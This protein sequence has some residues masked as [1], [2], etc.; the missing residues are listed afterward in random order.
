MKKKWFKEYL[1]DTLGSMALGL[2]SSLIV[3]L[4]LDQIGK[5]L[6][7]GLLV[8]LGRVAKFLMGPA[9]GIAVAYGR[10]APALA[11][12]S[13]A[14]TGAIG[15]GTVFLNSSNQ[16]G[17]TVGEPMGA[18]I[19][20]LA[21]VEVGRLVAGKTK[22]DIV[23]VPSTVIIVGGIV[24]KYVSPV[25]AAVMSAL[26]AII[27]TAT[28]LNPIPMGILVSVIMGMVLTLPISSAALAIALGLNG[29]AGGAATVG[30]CTQMVGFAV[31]SY[32]ENKIGGLIAQG[33]GTSM[34]Q[35]PNIIKNPLIW[36][37]P[38]LA[39][40]ILGPLST[41]I[42]KMEN[43][44]EGAGMGTSGLVGQ[45]GTFAAMSGTES[46][47]MILVKIFI[48]HIALP[49]ILTLVISEFMRKKGY[50]RPG[51]MKLDL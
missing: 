43:V 33:I 40:A 48:L 1:I 28:V 22:A 23:V 14:V 34:L 4:I 13:S 6:G 26:G 9:I 38:T 19:A 50:I 7:I 31:A 8:D 37:P 39:S 10:K 41:T 46:A 30:C 21:G 17:I 35:V 18:F 27:N 36:I 16:Y 5:I 29:L 3:G 20:A 49:A 25:V 45:F 12:F 2:F 44:P 15:A 11:V 32:R 47:G 24:G 51:D 42:F